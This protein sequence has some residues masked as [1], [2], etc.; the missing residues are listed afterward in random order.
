MGETEYNQ[1]REGQI[2]HIVTQSV[3]TGPGWAQEMDAYFGMEAQIV[4]VYGS[5]D[6]FELDI[7][8]GQ[9]IWCPEMFQEYI[10]YILEDAFASALM[11][12]LFDGL[13]AYYERRKNNEETKT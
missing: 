6:R 8:S 3:D 9:F 1:F 2:V 13:C 11:D 4:D 5:G 12:S 7:D 10:G